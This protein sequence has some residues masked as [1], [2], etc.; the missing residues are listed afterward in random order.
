LRGGRAKIGAAG[1]AGEFAL[2]GYTIKA[3]SE[4]TKLSEH[5]LR[6]YEKEGL[7]P[8]IGRNAS[9]VR[10]YSNGDL[11]W[12]G[13][14]C[15]LKNTGMSIRQIRDFVNLSSQGPRT[16]E[17]RRDMLIEHKLSVEAHIGEMHR[18]L[19]KVA[20]K[21]AYFTE[22][23]ERYGAGGDPEISGELD[24][25]DAPESGLKEPACR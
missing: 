10:R 2:M 6:Y 8:H 23:C 5:A 13:L 9:G 21:I 11:E 15:C 24:T 19:D 12:L 14:I 7:L 16:L 20:R 4:K 22:Q 17:A 25:S 18:H 1:F 3:V